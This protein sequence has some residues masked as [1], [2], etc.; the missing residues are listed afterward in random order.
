MNAVQRSMAIEG[1]GLAAA[2]GV[3]HDASDRFQ[4][5]DEYAAAIRWVVGYLE[6]ELSRAEA[7]EE[8]QLASPLDG[9]AA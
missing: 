5:S 2:A 4:A 6:W 9:H 1:W 7:N 3:L 8:R